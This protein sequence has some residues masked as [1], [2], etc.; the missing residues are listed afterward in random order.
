MQPFSRTALSTAEFDL[1]LQSSEVCFPWSV[2]ATEPV[3]AIIPRIGDQPGAPEPSRSL[4]KFPP[5]TIPHF[6]DR[7]R[8]S[9]D[10]H[11]NYPGARY[12]SRAPSRHSTVPQP[13]IARYSCADKYLEQGHHRMSAQIL[14]RDQSGSRA[15]SCTPSKQFSPPI[16]P[17]SP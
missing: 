8:L 12:P 3:L 7:V 10:I 14:W 6:K 17:A 5:P 4:S 13:P 11:I 1:E 2:A 16:R 15:E 9:G